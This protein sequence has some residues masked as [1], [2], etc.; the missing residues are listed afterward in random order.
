M[1]K[2]TLVVEVEAEEEKI[3]ELLAELE[4]RESEGEFDIKAITIR[5]AA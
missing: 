3:G 1:D 5:K 2:Q 4:K